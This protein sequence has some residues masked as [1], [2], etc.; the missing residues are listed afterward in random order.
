MVFLPRPPQCGDDRHAPSCSC[1]ALDGAHGCFVGAQQA[2][3]KLSSKPYVFLRDILCVSCAACA[4]HHMCVVVR[5]QLWRVRSLLPRGFCSSHLG[6]LLPCRA[7][8]LQQSCPGFLSTGATHMH[9]HAQH[10][11]CPFVPKVLG[12]LLPIFTC[13]VSGTQKSTEP[14]PFWK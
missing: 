12:P 2:F 9:C 14:V 4:C 7:L 5:G 11:F 1:P 6:W 10:Q 13:W 8:T 3:Y